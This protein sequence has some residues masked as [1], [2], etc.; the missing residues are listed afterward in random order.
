MVEPRLVFG[1]DA[2]LYDRARASYPDE[3]IDDLLDLVEAPVRALDVGCGTGKAAVLLA[4]RGVTGVGVDAH[5]D[6]AVVARRNLE[7]F[8]TWRIDVCDFESW[9][10]QPGDVPFD[11]V[12]CAQAWHWLDPDIRIR[13]AHDLLRPGGWLALW[14]N[15]PAERAHHLDDRLDAIYAEVA[16]GVRRTIG[17]KGT[18]P[19]DDIPED[20][21]LCDPFTITYDWSRIYTSAQWCDL[22]RT[23]SDHRLLD[24]AQSDQLLAG[25]AAV[26]DAD[27]GAYE[28]HYSTHFWA[29]QRSD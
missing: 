2:E 20:V 12:T 27:G 18:P 6:M 1:E 4:E 24:P 15:R 9:T 8:G 14:W 13:R 11:L 17:H 23:Q 19:S 7:E 22:M 26:I 10:P 29:A 3:L 21:W 16:P 28:H 25:V 5:E